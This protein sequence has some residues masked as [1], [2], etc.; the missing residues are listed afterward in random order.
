MTVAIPIYRHR[1]TYTYP[2]HSD[3]YSYTFSP[4][5]DVSH[6]VQGGLQVGFSD[7]SGERP[8]MLIHSPEGSR[9]AQSEHGEQM[10]YLPDQDAG[11][12]AREALATRERGL[13][14]RFTR[15]YDEW[16]ARRSP[17]GSVD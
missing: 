2:S 15:L 10:L 7:A 8:Y 12:T 4:T 11:Y 17:C 3:G 9:V 6:T 16:V 14:Q 13:K 5:P 1:V